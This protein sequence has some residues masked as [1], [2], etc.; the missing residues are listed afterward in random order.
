[1]SFYEK[2]E[3]LAELR[4]DGIKS[5]VARNITTGEA[6][7]AHLFVAGRSPENQALLDKLDRLSPADSNYILE[8][9][10]NQGTPYVIARLLPDRVS[11]RDWLNTR[12]AAAPAPVPAET[13]PA[14]RVQEALEKGETLPAFKVPEALARGETLPAFK[15]PEALAKGETLPAF[16]VQEA[17]EKGETLPAFKVPEALQRGETL[18]PFAAPGAKQG[19]APPSGL[20][21]ALE[22]GE[23]LPPF[24]AMEAL[25]KGETLPPFRAWTA[26]AS[27]SEPKAAAPAAPPRKRTG[28]E[29][30]LKLFQVPERGK[31]G[32]S[33]SSAPPTPLPAEK[34]SSAMSGQEPPAAPAAGAGE[35]T[36][37]FSA[38]SAAP[39]PPAQPAAAQ[40]AEPPAAPQPPPVTPAP[41]APA[42]GA[43]EF[44]RMFSAPSA[45][46]HAPAQ[47][48]AAQPAEPPAAPQPP[49][50][51]PAPFAPAPAAPAA[52]A[53]EFTSLFAAPPQAQQP[54][55]A[56]AT[57]QPPAAAPAPPAG[58]S[59]FTRMF[60]APPGAGAAPLQSP[61]LGAA[62][63]LGGGKPGEFTRMFSSPGGSLSQPGGNLP[64]GLPGASSA[65]P[66][67]A[68]PPKSSGG[69]I[70]RLATG[71]TCR[72]ADAASRR[73]RSR[74]AG[75][76]DAGVSNAFRAQPDGTQPDTDRAERIYADDDGAGRGRSTG[77]RRRRARRRSRWG[78]RIWHGLHG[79]H[80]EL[81][82]STVYEAAD[83]GATDVRAANGDA[84]IQCRL[85]WRPYVGPDIQRAPNVRAAGLQPFAVRPANEHE[86][87]ESVAVEFADAA[88]AEP[89][90]GWSREQ[91]DVHRAGRSVVDCHYRG[92]RFRDEELVPWRICR[93]HRAHK[94]PQESGNC[95]GRRAS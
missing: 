81:L 55:A 49:P 38:P 47:P 60:N 13:L 11:L 21:A 91:G 69:S 56:P 80:G 32:T 51:T 20:E 1:M 24:R 65:D 46:P 30:F 48:A 54:P 27:G 26:P 77:G 88:D 28:D 45:A 42:A 62:P 63:P 95:C 29:E 23:T 74:C 68:G 64:A 89:S 43:G 50:A 33:T 87:G 44:T 90:E 40:P 58:G 7:E 82:R 73:C 83:D 3:L 35:F 12:V 31:P 2:Y 86:L 41:A 52:G 78:R 6:V 84:A 70:W 93:N 19:G 5:F 14:F 25:E 37:M 94:T 66:F 39:Q 18:P 36:R 9:G 79:R 34:L 59:E 67:A 53:G 16:R 17:L 85:G 76:R 22:R 57:P 72:I 10:E 8:R 75:R 15:V 71:R 92:H 61:P 4:D